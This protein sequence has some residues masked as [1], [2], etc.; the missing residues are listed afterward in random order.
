MDEVERSKQ[1][2]QTQQWNRCEDEETKIKT[3]CKDKPNIIYTLT[4]D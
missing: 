4:Y 1:I 2:K 3:R